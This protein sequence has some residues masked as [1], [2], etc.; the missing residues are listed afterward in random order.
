MTIGMITL[1]FFIICG[2]LN[3]GFTF[4][5][6]QGKVYPP[7]K[8]RLYKWHREIAVESIWLSFI[9]LICIIGNKEYRYGLKFW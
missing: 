7:D 6:F 3:Y 1:L 2:I 9:T 4:A 8:Q 5:Y